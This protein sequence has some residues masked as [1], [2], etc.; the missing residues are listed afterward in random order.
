MVVVVKHIRLFRLS[1]LVLCCCRIR[2]DTTSWLLR[3]RIAII[4]LYFIL[5]AFLIYTFSILA[6]HIFFN[7]NSFSFS[8]QIPSALIFLLLFGLIF[9]IQFLKDLLFF[10]FWLIFVSFFLFW[11]LHRWL[12]FKH[13]TK[14]LVKLRKSFFIGT[15][16]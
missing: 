1:L 11:S 13:S 15:F 10:L 3:I 9:L 7:L 16:I 14:Y 2:R 12:S 5:C 4:N 8:F 6:Y